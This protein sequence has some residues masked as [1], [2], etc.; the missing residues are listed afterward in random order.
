M[1]LSKVLA[2][3][4]VTVALTGSLFAQDSLNITKLSQWK[5]GIQSVYNEVWGI[6]QNGREYAIIGTWSGTYFIDVTDPANPVQV[7]YV[8]GVDEACFC[9]HRDYHD[10]NGYLYMVTD[11]D[12]GTL[13]I[14]DLSN[15]P[16][17]VSVVYDSD[18]LFTRSHN[19]FIDSSSALLYSCGGDPNSGIS[20]YSLANPTNPVLLKDFQVPGGYVH[21][22]YVRNDTVYAHAGGNGMYVYDFSNV[23]TPVL[24]GS[25][26]FYPDKGYNH[27]G[28]LSDDGNTYVFADET[29]NMDV[30]VC[31]VSD[32][33]DILVIDTV[34]TGPDTN[35]MP[36]NPII[37]GDYA[38][39]S[40]YMAGLWIYDISNPGNTTVAGYYDPTFGAGDTLTSGGAWGV[41]PFL[42]SGNILVSSM[43]SGLF[44]FD[45][46]EATTN[47]EEIEV[48]G[49]GMTISP[50]P[51]IDKV[52]IRFDERVE[53]NSV[54][55]FDMAG[56]VVSH[57]ETKSS[58]NSIE[59]SIGELNS[60]QYIIHVL[61]DRGNIVG[62]IT[63]AA[64]NE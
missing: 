21:D 11:E 62:T 57:S 53:I 60:G 47:I 48:S 58:G 14:V 59:Y 27:A 9:I 6:A 39:I 1:R 22:V 35:Q 46:S 32:L 17:S 28:W 19:I 7:D 24:I 45:V 25:L 52:T 33:T 26:E 20:V 16:I 31:D 50:N 41:Y 13:Q 12:P 23:G 38:F 63:K 54:R 34:D 55:I 36:H 8:A 44:V 49:I 51:F 2:L 18:A 10:Y 30:K 61:T 43:G 42:P 5:T 56:K 29:T 3:L 64:A 15:L 40:Y 37:K 4:F